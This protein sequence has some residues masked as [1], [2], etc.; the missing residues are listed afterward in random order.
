V[1]NFTQFYSS[2]DT[3]APVLTG[4]A[5]KMIALLDAIL[6]NGYTAA[7][8]TSITESGTTYTVT[9]AASQ[10]LITGNYVKIAG[11]TGGFTSLNA[12]W[13]PITV[14][15]AT[16]FTFVGPGGLGT[17]ATGTIT[18][19]KAPL[20][21]TSPY[22][23]ANRAA[24]RPQSVTGRTNQ[25]YLRIEEDGN[26]TGGQKECVATGGESM[27]DINTISAQFPTSAQIAISGTATKA[28]VCWRKSAT[29]DGTARSWRFVGDGATFYFIVDSETS[30][31]AGRCFCG[32]GG[33]KSFKSGDAYNTFI[34]GRSD[35][36]TTQNTSTG[37][38]GLAAVTNL[39]QTTLGANG[40]YV[41]RASSQTGGSVA[42][43]SL[44]PT[45]GNSN[46]N[47]IGQASLIQIPYPNV[48]DGALWVTPILLTETALSL[49]GIMPGL[50]MHMHS[51][52]PTNADDM[53]TTVTGLSGAT[54]IDFRT[55]GGGTTVGSALLDMFGSW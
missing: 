7:S 33:F 13:G 48:P 17:P 41:A 31:S 40:V 23:A 14:T 43:Q 46:A 15:S 9:T 4:Q 54:L 34:A 45:V 16:T 11:C 2:A 55:Q 47:L 53:V 18:W 42:A 19:A 21:W 38:Q 22:T 35:F 36:N 37:S 32:F 49:R 8:V 51:T 12:V 24:Y 52:I 6:V 1:P 26:T 20:G 30:T 5:G 27:S 50:Y 39:L 29:A 3:N 44:N 25:M 10:N 28:G